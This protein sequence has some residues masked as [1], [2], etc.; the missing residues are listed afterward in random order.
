MRF[1]LNVKLRDLITLISLVLWL[2]FWKTI[3]IFQESME[4]ICYHLE[5]TQLL[6]HFKDVGGLDRKSYHWDKNVKYL[7]LW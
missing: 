3:F 7:G 2:S 4:R 5:G 1:R 6:L